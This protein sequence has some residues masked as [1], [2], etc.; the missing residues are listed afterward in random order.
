MIDR[1]L[2]ERAGGARSSEEEQVAAVVC[3]PA[4][5]ARA[6]HKAATRLASV[7]RSPACC[8]CSCTFGRSAGELSNS[9]L[10]LCSSVYARLRRPR[11]RDMT[12]P[13]GADVHKH[14]PS[15]VTCWVNVHTTPM[16]V[17]QGI[18]TLIEECT[19][20]EPSRRPHSGA[21]AC[22]QVHACMLAAVRTAATCAGGVA[23][24]LVESA[25][26]ACTQQVLPPCKL[27]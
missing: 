17:V 19:A 8:C 1:R 4:P 9:H 22:M 27:R 18:V 7:G 5:A 15:V 26:P 23:S 2:K 21:G 6:Q 10:P 11:F 12:P 14:M 3:R 20:H 24:Q 13:S 16:V 25:T